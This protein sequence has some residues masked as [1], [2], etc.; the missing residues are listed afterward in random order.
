MFGQPVSIILA[1]VFDMYF[2]SF[3]GVPE[4]KREWLLD[5]AD[6]MRLYTDGRGVVLV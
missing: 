1:R 4:V 5:P 3:A 6:G 2:I